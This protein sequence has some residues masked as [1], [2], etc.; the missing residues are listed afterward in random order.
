[1]GSCVDLGSLFANGKRVPL[2]L[3]RVA[4]YLTRPV[5]AGIPIAVACLALPITD[6]GVESDLERS[7]A[8][9]SRACDLG[10]VVAC[11]NF[12][13]ALVTGQGVAKDV[14]R[15]VAI[16]TKAC[17]AGNAASCSSLGAPYSL[18]VGVK[19]SAAK[20]RRLFEKSCDGDDAGECPG[21]GLRSGAGGEKRSGA[22]DAALHDSLRPGRW[23]GV[24]QLGSLV[25]NGRG[26]GRDAVRA[27]ELFRKACDLKDADGCLHLGRAYQAGSGVTR[28]LTQAA[29]YF[30]RA[31]A[32][33]P[34]KT[35]ALRALSDL[36]EPRGTSAPSAERR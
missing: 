2:D 11:G 22:S 7:A 26:S 17:E 28:D 36:P 10:G 19:A 13:L 15:A 29:L 31:L 1:M 12:G 34:D 6:R 32:I 27:G 20:A 14:G 33:E 5:T 30:R 24:R 9:F 4:V 21:R 8:A 18:G 35:E 25:Q 23:R 16:F 3:P